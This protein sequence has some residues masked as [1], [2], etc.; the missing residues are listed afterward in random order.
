MFKS[1]SE[2]RR[3]LTVTAICSD[4]A[5]LEGLAGYL[6]R[7]VAY[8]AVLTLGRANEESMASDCVL[9]YPDGFPAR[10]AQR[11]AKRLISCATVSLVVIV[12]AQPSEYEVLERDRTTSSRLMVLSPPAWPWTLFAAIESSF[13]SVH[14]EA[15]RLSQRN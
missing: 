14:R 9:L 3:S 13:P 5:T 6:H 11:L 2:A 7:R 1:R 8:R 12:T 4:A 15:S 10:P